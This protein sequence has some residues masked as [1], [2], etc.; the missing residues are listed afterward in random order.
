MQPW[1]NI[2]T[3]AASSLHEQLGLGLKVWEERMQKKHSKEP[4]PRY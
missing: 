2:T 3:D 1:I 4:K